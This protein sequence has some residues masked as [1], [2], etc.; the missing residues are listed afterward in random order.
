MGYVLAGW[1]PL[2]KPDL[3]PPVSYLVDAWL[4]VAV[5]RTGLHM[6][7]YQPLRVQE[8]QCKAFFLRTQIMKRRGCGL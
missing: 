8:V 3:V 1:A 4:A 2:S 5:Q 6:L 7:R